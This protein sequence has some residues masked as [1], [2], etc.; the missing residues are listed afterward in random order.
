MKSAKQLYDAMLTEPAKPSLG[1]TSKKMELADKMFEGTKPK[2][3]AAGGYVKAADGCAQR[4]K[5]R[6]RM[7]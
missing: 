1:T 2:K 4:G 7:V 5:T 3:M 6:G